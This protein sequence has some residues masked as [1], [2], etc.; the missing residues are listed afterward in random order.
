[1]A[2]TAGIGSDHVDLPNV[3]KTEKNPNPTASM[4]ANGYLLMF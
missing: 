3:L 2:I 1:M 4:V